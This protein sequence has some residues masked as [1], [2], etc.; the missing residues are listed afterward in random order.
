M[1][2]RLGVWWAVLLV[3]TA[4]VIAVPIWRR[5]PIPAGATVV[6]AVNTVPTSVT[7][8]PAPLPIP[9]PIPVA[10]ASVVAPTP[11][12]GAPITSSAEARPPSPT[13]PSWP[14]G[15]KYVLHVGDS[16]LGFEQG[17][18]LEMG[19][20]FK[21]AGVRYEAITELNGGLHD[22]AT[23]KKLAELLKW[24]KPDV[25]LLNFGMNNLTVARPE[26]YEVDVK[27][28]VAQVGD[29]ACFWIGPLSIGRPEKGLIAMLGRTAAPCGWT[30]SYD[31]DIE[32]QS[33]RL[34]PTQP[35]ASHW[36]DAIWIALGAPV[37]NNLQ[38]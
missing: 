19:T 36:A 24:K 26:D 18:A 35:G 37:V 8:P 12:P 10:V 27:S 28:I 14:A 32:R 6:P 31:L 15:A 11:P 30:N 22:F 34:H 16:S 21:A 13:N 4:V 2:R 7:A 20:R 38:K 23:S 29:R 17:L 25:V 3:L 33:D 5:K 9:V 1:M